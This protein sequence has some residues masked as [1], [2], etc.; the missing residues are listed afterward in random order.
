MN[1][2]VFITLVLSA[3]FVIPM[4]GYYQL[5]D[6]TQ[7]SKTWKLFIFTGFLMLFLGV[8]LALKVL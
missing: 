5:K 2:A 4:L 6:N 3:G 8:C 1:K 7:N